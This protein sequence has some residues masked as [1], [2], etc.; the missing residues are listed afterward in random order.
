MFSKKSKKTTSNRSSGPPK[1]D[2]VGLL[3]EAIDR[4]TAVGIVHAGRAG[5]D[6][7]AQGRMLQWKNNALIIEELQI[8]GRDVVL[9]AGDRVEAY[10]SYNGTM[11]TFEAEVLEVELPS[12]LNSERI[13]RALH[14]TT[15]TN[16]REGDRRSAFR[17][18]L[19]GIAEDF[20]VRMWFLDRYTANDTKGTADNSEGK[21]VS[22]SE[23]SNNAY[24]TDLLAA[25]NFDANIPLDENGVEY[26]DISWKPLLDA[27]MLEFPHARGRLVDMT[28]NGFGILMY[29]ISSMQLDRFERIGMSFELEGTKL[30]FVVE[31]RQGTDLRGST[32]RVGTLI[33]YPDRGEAAVQSKRLIERFAMQIQRDHL[34]T[35]SVA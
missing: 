5:K 13:V 29:G 18:S 14:I 21:I 20:P 19:S 9:K 23:K 12:R 7:L 30:D 8:I 16:L 35:R 25:K 28:S 3:N 17:A 11:M 22:T 24:Y 26:R 34:R 1:V 4:N 31:V 15:P 10:L 33:V 32:C 6:P 2:Y 27:T